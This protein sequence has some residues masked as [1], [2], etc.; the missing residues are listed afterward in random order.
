MLVLNGVLYTIIMIHLQADI[1]IAW[2]QI[3]Q[4]KYNIINHKYVVRNILYI[5]RLTYTVSNTLLVI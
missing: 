2:P 5:T 3:F 4:T 1:Y